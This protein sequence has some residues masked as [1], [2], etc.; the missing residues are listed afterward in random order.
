MVGDTRISLA[1][2]YET[3]RFLR[4]L[5]VLPP[6]GKPRFPSTFLV[7]IPIASKK[8]SIIKNGNFF[9]GGRNSTLFEYVKNLSQNINKKTVY[10]WADCYKQMQLLGV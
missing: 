3:H 2:L 8:I 5:A 6:Q 1:S 4:Q 10:Q 9:T 7:R